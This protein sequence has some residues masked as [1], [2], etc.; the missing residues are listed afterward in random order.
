MESDIEEIVQTCNST[1]NIYFEKFAELIGNHV[2]G[3]VSHAIFPVSSGKIEGI[4]NM[5]KTIRRSA[6]GYND[7]EYF[8]L[9]AMDQSRRIYVR[10]PKS[11]KIFQ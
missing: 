10:N 11:H 1:N 2:D 7:D 3:I 6:Y 4:N 5:M 8:F 9:K